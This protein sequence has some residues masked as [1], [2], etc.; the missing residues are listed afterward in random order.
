MQL[1]K[2]WFVPQ[3]TAIILSL[4]S[5]TLIL[6]GAVVSLGKNIPQTDILT[7]YITG[8]LLA[9]GIGL[10][11]LLIPFSPQTKRS[12]ITIWIVKTLITLGFMLL[13]ES[14]Y[15]VVDA[16]GYFNLPRQN[17]EWTGFSLFGKGNGSTENIYNLVW[18]Y[19]KVFPESYHGLKVS[20]ALIGL[21]ATYVYYQ[22]AVLFIEREDVRILYG[23]GLYPS[24]IFWSAIIGK[25]PLSFLAIAFYT[26]GVVGTYRHKKPWYVFIVF[27]G[28]LLAIFIRT[29]LGVIL[30]IP[31]IIL[32]FQSIKNIWM[33][34]IFLFFTSS[35]LVLAFKILQAQFGIVSFQDVADKFFL[36]AGE[37]SDMWFLGKNL[38]VYLTEPYQI[39]AFIPLGM[40]LTL[41]RPFPGDPFN[42][43]S[44]L[45]LMSNLPLLILLGFAFARSRWH[46]F[47]EP[48]VLW[49]TVL[50]ITWAGVYAF[51]SSDRYRI[52]ILPILLGL[53]LYLGCK[54]MPENLKYDRSKL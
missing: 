42:P 24:L 50:I 39:I 41:F 7:D 28:L 37:W 35:I 20:F 4:L 25:D 13:Y 45:S 21:I 23:L 49:A 5:A 33:R 53:L 47:K 52:Q 14:Y 12:L 9:L 34:S 11:I 38:P 19:Y 18:L 44:W 17:F 48:L 36:V 40:L 10:V 30:L 32:S 6:S 27:L 26:Y 8:V 46:D 22:A 16:Y 43:F 51:T 1:N 15:D 31:V 2:Y 3:V 54:R 29:W